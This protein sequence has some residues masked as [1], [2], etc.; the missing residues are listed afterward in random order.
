MSTG[1]SRDKQTDGVERSPETDSHMCGYL[2]QKFHGVRAI[3]LINW[4]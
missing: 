3:F 4:F 1:V 2:R